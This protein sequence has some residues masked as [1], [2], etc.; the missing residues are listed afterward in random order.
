M[1]IKLCVQCKEELPIGCKLYCSKACKKKY[2]TVTGKDSRYRKLTIHT[3]PCF[4][5]KALIYTKMCNRKYCNDCRKEIQKLADKSGQRPD[6]KC[7]RCGNRTRHISNVC[8][9]CRTNSFDKYNPLLFKNTPKI[10]E[11]L[12]RIKRTGFTNAVDVYQ[13]CSYYCMLTSNVTEYNSLDVE[14]QV[15]KMLDRL[16]L[17]IKSINNPPILK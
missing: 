9:L 15:A 12:D 14:E 10:I 4:K 2:Y 3:I 8:I 6:S 13:I 5:C 1:E 7:I 11:F 17:Y 16:T